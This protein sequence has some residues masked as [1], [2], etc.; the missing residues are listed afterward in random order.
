VLAILGNG[1]IFSIYAESLL[2]IIFMSLL[3]WS[4]FGQLHP[5]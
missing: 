2:S 1:K 4:G 5:A 3:E